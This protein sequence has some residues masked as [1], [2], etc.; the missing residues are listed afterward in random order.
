[1]VKSF[2]SVLVSDASSYHP[3][4]LT[5]HLISNWTMEEWMNEVI[6]I[7][8]I[9]EQ[10]LGKCSGGDSKNDGQT[11]SLCPSSHSFWWGSCLVH[12]SDVSR[13]ESCSALTSVGWGLSFFS[14]EWCWRHTLEQLYTVWMVRDTSA[15]LWPLF[16]W[17]VRIK[18]LPVLV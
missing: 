4:M 2:A 12:W 11:S 9:Y 5:Q 10:F 18:N 13:M 14:V 3:Q 17:A 7:L 8:K 6:R 16:L 15:L 1:M